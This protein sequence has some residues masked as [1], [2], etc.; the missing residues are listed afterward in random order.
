[1]K[2]ITIAGICSLVLMAGFVATPVAQASEATSTAT[3]TVAT[4]TVATTTVATTTPVLATTTPIVTSH[5]ADLL[6]QLAKLTA[7][8][9]ELKAKLL[10]VQTQ[11]TELKSDLREGMSDADI[12]AIQVA[13]AS[14]PTIYPAGLTTGF[15]GPMTAEAIKRFQAKNGLVVTGTI[16]AETKAALD[17]ILAQHRKEGHFPMG[18]LIAP[19]QH[20]DDFEDRVKANCGLISPSVTESTPCQLM[21]EKYHFDMSGKRNSPT[22][23]GNSAYGHSMHGD[24]ASSTEKEKDEKDGKDEKSDDDN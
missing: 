20:R 6:A 14:D 23:P 19:G 1:M 18:L 9:N 15:F 7:L 12:K 16:N 3:T 2:D 11:I 10:G 24:S 4:T 22:L 21:R 13:L 17:T 5:I 8:F